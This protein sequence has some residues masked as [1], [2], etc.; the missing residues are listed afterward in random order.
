MKKIIFPLMFIF[1]LTSVLAVN[2]ADCTTLSSASTTYD[3]TGDITNKNWVAGACMDITA[4]NVILDCH[5]Y[6]IDGMRVD[7]DVST[8]NSQAVNI[9]GNN[10]EVKNCVISDWIT[11]IYVSSGT[12]FADV[13]DN[14]IFNLSST[15]GTNGALGTQG[16]DGGN[17]NGLWVQNHNNGTF[18]DNTIYNLIGGTGGTGGGDGNG[19]TGGMARAIYL[20]GGSIDNYFADNV[21]YDIYGG[22]GGNHGAELNLPPAPDGKN[23]STS[24]FYI[25]SSFDNILTPMAGS[26]P[27]SAEMNTVDG[28]GVLYFYNQN[29]IVVD[30]FNVDTDDVSPITIGTVSDIDYHTGVFLYKVNNSIISNI[31]VSGF[32]QGGDYDALTTGIQL[33]EAYFNIVAN[34]TISDLIGGGGSA[35]GLF[36]GGDEGGTGTGIY[37]LESENNTL[38]G[39]DI[40]LI[41]GGYGGFGGNAG[42]GGTGGVSTGFYF[43]D[44]KLNLLY[45]NTISNLVGGIGGDAYKGSNTDG[46]DQQSWAIWLDAN[47]FNNTITSISDKEVDFNKTNYIG[48]SPLLYFY[49]DSNLAINGKEIDSLI[50]PFL[51]GDVSDTVTAGIVFNQI[52]DSTINQNEISGFAGFSG[53]TGIAQYSNGE[54]GHEASGIYLIDSDDNDVQF[55]DI[56]LI[57]G[58][59]GGGSGKNAGGGDGGEGLGIYIVDSSGINLTNNLIINSTGGVRGNRGYDGSYGSIGDGVSVWLN[60]A[61]NI[62]FFDNDLSDSDG[63]NEYAIYVDGTTNGIISNNLFDANDNVTITASTNFWN[64][65]SSGNFWTNQA[66]NGFSDTCT[67]VGAP[68]GICDSSLTLSAGNIDYLPLSVSPSISIPAQ[69]ND[70]ID[71]DLDGFIDLLDTGCTS[72]SDDSESDILVECWDGIDND[73]D[74]FID[75]PSDPSCDSPTDNNE[76]PMD[77]YQCNDSIDNDFDG[78]IDLDDPSC[79]FWNDTTELPQD[80]PQ[81]NDS[82]DNDLDGLIDLD[83]PSCQSSSGITEF[84]ADVSYQEESD[85]FVE[86]NCILYDDVPYNDNPALHGWWGDLIESNADYEYRGGYSIWLDAYDEDLDFVYSLEA[87]KNITNPNNYN[88]VNGRVVMSIIDTYGLAVGEYSTPIYVSFTDI[89]GNIVGSLRMNFSDEDTGSYSLKGDVYASDG[90]SYVYFD[91]IYLSSADDYLLFLDFEF[92]QINQ[93]YSFVIDDYESGTK[94]SS[95]YDS[96]SANTI[97]TVQF[98]H[99]LSDDFAEVLVSLVEL[100]GDD[101]LET[102]CT[103][104]ESPYY[105]EEY[106]NGFINLCDWST[107]HNI[108][109]NG[110]LY[111]TQSI[112]FYYAQKLMFGTIEDDATRYATWQFDLKLTNITSGNTLTFRMYDEEQTNFIT[113]YVDSSQNLYYDDDGTGTLVQSNIPL[114][115]YFSYQFIVDLNED[116]FDI[117]FN[118]STVV[119]NAEFTD[120]FFNI[121][122]IEYIKFSS[123]TSEY[124][125]DDMLVFGSTETG[126]AQT[127][128]VDVPVDIVDETKSWCNLF[129]S[130]TSTC[131]TDNDCGSGSCLPNG[132]CNSFDMTYCDDNG[133]K[134]GNYCIVAGM[135]SCVLE[136]TSDL[137]LDN[138]LLFLVLLILIVLVVYIILSLK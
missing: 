61:D 114:D 53:H 51:L 11:G 78:F 24:G 95:Q 109:A 91:T 55:N 110:E 6:T 12:S 45:S 44:S 5:G 116:T 133:H 65:T 49:D 16:G 38:Y 136:S 103:T 28:G 26:S 50:A 59:T 58:G 113:V 87:K 105:L 2:I 56:S 89:T 69:C 79:N 117:I 126:E 100:T 43:D 71:N 90:A 135:T 39:N 25:H 67:D 36:T 92:D 41:T 20:L 132:K 101:T 31:E 121:E 19:G 112:P 122:T 88:N 8:L 72:P 63:T 64:D 84:P 75:Y 81:C 80:N 62:D 123:S 37:I 15:Q 82:I 33:Y 98:N 97:Y 73:G 14:T 125:L 60:N 99:A 107:S 27:N 48:T 119:S 131:T 3:L 96:F 21:I 124:Y 13:H 102:V 34:N 130:E 52:T 118:D 138:F 127:P 134:R 4:N 40:S 76:S 70:G 7:G 86:E 93:E 47:S 137:I 115:E 42:T 57:T 68:I 54:D 120:S 9:N 23:G 108:Y 22:D 77:Y 30:N 94:S 35:G 74:G 106:F 66:S 128:D 18:E 29:N 129:S 1:M 17:V 104:P 111:L 10:V 83:D 85:C 46:A 32:H